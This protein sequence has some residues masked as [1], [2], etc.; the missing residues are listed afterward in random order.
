MK[1]KKP[2]IYIGLISCIFL[3]AII[4]YTIYKSPISKQQNSNSIKSSDVSKDQNSS[5]SN[6]PSEPFKDYPE[7]KTLVATLPKITDI[8]KDY[9]FENKFIL[10]QT[11]TSM[12]DE[13]GVVRVNL[14][15]YCRNKSKEDFSCKDRTIIDMRISTA[16]NYE[17][18]V[19][20]LIINQI[21]KDSESGKK[22]LDFYLDGLKKQQ[23]S[24]EMTC[25]VRDG[26]LANKDKTLF[27]YGFI[28]DGTSN[29]EYQNESY[30]ILDKLKENNNMEYV[31]RCDQKIN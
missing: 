31:F 26:L 23:D 1:I 29:P 25:T 7:S 24:G 6:S 28:P 15:D 17:K 20:V 10:E 4:S 16:A 27:V 8:P 13:N 9:K 21:A 30:N 5:V 2:Y 22:L 19:V 12:V 3:V 18:K 14:D 11:K